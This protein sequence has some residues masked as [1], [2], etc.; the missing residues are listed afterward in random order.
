MKVRCAL[1]LKCPYAKTAR[2]LA[3]VLSPDNRS[4]PKEQNLIQSLDGGVLSFF[5]ET[6]S[7]PSLSTTVLSLL[8][9]AELFQEVWLL[10]RGGRAR[11]ARGKLA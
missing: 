2:M 11:R 6:G 4:I 7:I 1:S 3:D 10:S 9:D 8:T 5:I